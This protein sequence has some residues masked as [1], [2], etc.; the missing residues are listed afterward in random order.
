MIKENLI[1]PVIKEVDQEVIALYSM[2]FG[3]RV[4]IY[5]GDIIDINTTNEELSEII[6]NFSQVES[7]IRE[8]KLNNILNE[9]LYTFDENYKKVAN[10][11]Y[12][13]VPFI[14]NE[15]N[16]EYKLH[17][18]ML[19]DWEEVINRCKKLNWRNYI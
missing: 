17:A 18:K 8:D 2:D 6:Y 9:I 15:L 12:E 11:L 3:L 14:I 7:K 10:E 16:D 1:Y 13:R 19:L 5:D 4:H